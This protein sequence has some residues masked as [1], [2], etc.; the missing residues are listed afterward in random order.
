[1]ANR[2]KKWVVGIGVPLATVAHA[3]A[4]DNSISYAHEVYAED[5]DRM[6]VQTDTVLVHGTLSRSLDL[7]AR[8]IYD[9]ISGATPTGAPPVD[10]LKLQNPRTHTPIPPSTITG[11]ALPLHGV[12]GASPPHITPNDAVPLA[13]S[14]DIRRAFD[15]SAG[16]TSGINRIVPEFSYSKEHDY[17][18]YGAA[19]NYSIELNEKNTVLN[20]GWSHDYDR[21]LNNR[22]TYITSR[23]IKSTDDIVLGGSQ[24]LTPGT[25][26]TAS[27]T[28]GFSEGYL[29]DPYRSVV[30]EETQ[31]DPNGRVILNGEKRPSNRDSQAILLSLTQAI[32][33]L[34]ASVEGSY[35]FY[36]DS[37]GINAN[38]FGIAWFQKFG[39][40]VVV[41]PSFRY[42]RQSA[43]DFYGTQFPGDPTFN[44]S[45]VPRF[46]SSDYRLS[47][48]ES[49]TLGL[50]ANVKLHEHWNL[51]L[52]YQ[53]YWMRGVDHETV[54]ST[55]PAASI[56]TIGLNFTF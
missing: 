55:Y 52:G 18:S 4:D 48:L 56:Y 14:A 2:S 46:Y 35:R 16:F 39:Q 37:F 54:Q 5:H 31:L 10:Q 50:Q 33:P 29:N 53:R 36:H 40:A 23:K 34:N 43:A 3:R 32:K 25:L 42:Y 20:V 12:S 19:L 9:G 27:G 17:I 8:G 51:Q 26:F 44:P 30:F 45:R 11:Y 22:F 38:T 6:T 7:T 24:I 49:F 47:A 21:V 1:M 13:H 15:L 28:F 41:S